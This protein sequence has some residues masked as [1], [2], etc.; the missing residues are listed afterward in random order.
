[1]R[2]KRSGATLVEL[3]VS[4]AI[5][6]TLLG[7]LLPA[8]QMVRAA[9][10]YTEHMNWLRQRRLGEQP[11]RKRLRAVFVGNSKTYWNDIPGIVVELAKDRGVELSTK[12]VAVGGQTLE[13]HWDGEEAQA[14]ITGDWSDFVVFQ[15][16]SYREYSA[17]EWPLYMDYATRFVQLCK[18]DAV[19]V[20]YSTWGYRDWPSLRQ[21]ITGHAFAVINDE[22]NTHAEVC[23][24]GEAWW[25][26]GNPDLFDDDRHPSPKG[27]YLSACVF[28][29]L[30]HQTSPERLTNSLTT[31][32]GVRV[33]IDPATA[34]T[35]QKSAWQTV[36]KFK[37]KNKPRYLRLK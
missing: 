6:G 8:V 18:R 11:F 34:L 16:Q 17:D 24:V 23:P 4:V 32:S 13:G 25:E 22:R 3:L 20:I 31:K 21:T 26:S 2:N 37:E 36:L 29:A 15:E 14:A 19:P 33:D 7:L 10:E 35:L 30:L 9:A 28:H 12:V 1:M 27:A 5:V